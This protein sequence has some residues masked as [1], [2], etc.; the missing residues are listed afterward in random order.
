MRIVGLNLLSCL[1]VI[2]GGEPVRAIQDAIYV[3]MVEATTFRAHVTCR[4]NSGSFPLSVAVGLRREAAIENHYALP[5]GC[6]SN[7]D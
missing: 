3:P 1:L 7:L 6:V 4:I 2:L 5:A